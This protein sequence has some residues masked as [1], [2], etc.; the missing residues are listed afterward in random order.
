MTPQERD[1]FLEKAR[2]LADAAG[3]WKQKL[4][5]AS[6]T[7]GRATCPLCG[8]VETVRVAIVP[9]RGGWH[10]RCKCSS[11]GVSQME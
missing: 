9:A 7:T 11:C 8:G 5:A 3:R 10:V 6:K 4:I 1:D 2:K